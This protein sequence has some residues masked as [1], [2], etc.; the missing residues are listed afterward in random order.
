MILKFEI[1]LKVYAELAVVDSTLIL[2]SEIECAGEAL[3]RG[4]SMYCFEGGQCQLG[5]LAK[6]LAKG[7]TKKCMSNKGKRKKMFLTLC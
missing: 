6:P 7:S 1:F 5:G 3:L 2:G 4:S